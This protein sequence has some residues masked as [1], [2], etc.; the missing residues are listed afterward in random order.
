LSEQEKVQAV[1]RVLALGGDPVEAVGHLECLAVQIFSFDSCVEIR[2]E[3]LD[4]PSCQWSNTPGRIRLQEGSLQRSATT[5]AGAVAG[6][7]RL[8]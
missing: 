7:E 2:R 5:A 3:Y 6:E 8:K 4:K 1:Q